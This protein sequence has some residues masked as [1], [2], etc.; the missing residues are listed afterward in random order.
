MT[1]IYPLELKKGITYRIVHKD[2]GIDEQVGVF[3]RLVGTRP[4][5][6]AMFTDI[7]GEKIFPSPDAAYRIDEWKFLKSVDPDDPQPLTDGGRRR[8]RK[9]RKSKRRHRKTRRSRK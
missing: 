7:R 3:D 6:N 1:E 8:R 2:G 4:N 9:T 5:V